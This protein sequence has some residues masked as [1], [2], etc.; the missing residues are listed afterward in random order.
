MKINKCFDGTYQTSNKYR[1]TP[2]ASSSGLTTSFCRSFP[3]AWHGPQ[4]HL[5]PPPGTCC[6]D[7]GPSGRWSGTDGVFS[8]GPGPPCPA[9]R[10]SWKSFCWRKLTTDVVWR[11]R[12]KTDWAVAGAVWRVVGWRDGGDVGSCGGGVQSAAKGVVAGD[13]VASGFCVLRA[14]K[15]V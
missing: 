8:R 10:T 6:T 15:C 13:L 1:K 12:G 3:T 7:A 9:G 14:L 2:S 4:S 11:V 5:D